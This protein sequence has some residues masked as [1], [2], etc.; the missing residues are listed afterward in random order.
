MLRR[1]SEGAVGFW[2]FVRYI[3]SAKTNPLNV[4]ISTGFSIDEPIRGANSSR[5]ETKHLT[6]I[7][8]TKRSHRMHRA[9]NLTRKNKPIKC[10]KFKEFS[11]L[12]LEKL[13]ISS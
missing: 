5:R 4:G 2:R 1:P 13:R 6:A 8:V 11:I 10:W 3:E 7:D 9:L 12:G